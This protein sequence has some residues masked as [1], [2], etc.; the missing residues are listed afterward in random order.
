MSHLG[1]WDPV[2]GPASRTIAAGRSLIV[3]FMLDLG[4]GKAPQAIEH[5]LHMIADDSG[6]H[7]IV[8]RPLSVSQENPIVV[9]P[10]LRGVWMA[11][12]SVNNGADAA[13]RRAILITDGRPWLAQRY[14]IDWV[15]IQ[16]VD[17]RS[18]PGKAR[19]TKTRA[20]SVTISRSIASLP[21]RSSA[22]P[23]A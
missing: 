14:A 19:K 7:D 15:Q 4:D 16:K 3:Y 10:P 9:A 2:A 13:H 8:L 23:M 1:P 5:S 12:D 6:T 17:G 11:G 20:T 18:R 21:A 22:W